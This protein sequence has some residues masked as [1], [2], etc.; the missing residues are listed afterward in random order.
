MSLLEEQT[1]FWT[2]LKDLEKYKNENDGD[3]CV[4]QNYAKNQVL[5]TWVM[6][7]RALKRQGSPRMT[8]RRE[9]MLNSI[10][11][12][13][14]EYDAAWEEMYNQL[15]KYKAEHGV[16]RVPRSAGTLGRWVNNQRLRLGKKRTM[17]QNNSEKINQRINKLDS[18]RFEW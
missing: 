3:V 13:W 9:A 7:M 6:N 12:V 16:T 2:N 4:P 14:N 15:A 11:F 1:T 17:R 18:L 10:G 5:A 8:P